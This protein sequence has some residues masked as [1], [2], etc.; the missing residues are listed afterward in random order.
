[1]QWIILIGNSNFTLDTV[2]S[3]E[4][5]ESIKTYDVNKNRFCVDYEED[6]IF[7]DYIDSLQDDYELDE[8]KKIPITSPNFIMMTY[9]SKERLKKILQQKNFPQDIYIDNDFGLILPIERF[10]KLDMPIDENDVTK[11]NN[12]LLDS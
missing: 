3:I 4:Y 2:K 12:N 7:Y 8:L 6:H 5:Y 11:A 10:I 1:M 9:T